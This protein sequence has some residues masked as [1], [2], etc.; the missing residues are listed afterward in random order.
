VKG[1]A[2]TLCIGLV[3]TVFTAVFVTRMYYDWKL[4]RRQLVAVS[5]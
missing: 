3:T 5:V 1:F 2:V 4:S